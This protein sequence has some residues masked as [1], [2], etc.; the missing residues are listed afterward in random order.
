MLTGSM[1]ETFGS[2]LAYEKASDTVVTATSIQMIGTRITVV[3]HEMVLTLLQPVLVR[4]L[5]PRLR[6]VVHVVTDNPVQDDGRVR[7]FVGDQ[8]QESAGQPAKAICE[9]REELDR[10][11]P[12]AFLEE[13]S[14]LVVEVVHVVSRH[15]VLVQAS[16]VV[17]KIH[18]VVGHVERNERLWVNTTR[19]REAYIDHTYRALVSHPPLDGHA[20][21]SNPTRC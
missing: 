13:V 1:T 6:D 10:L 7:T 16:E 9:V 4:G 19:E 5:L 15:Q 12:V 21:S 3:R 20:P 14:E 18:L 17:S 8:I 11:Q 2:M